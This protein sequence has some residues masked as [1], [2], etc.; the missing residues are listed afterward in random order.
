ML[1]VDAAEVAVEP[2]DGAVSRETAR[3]QGEFEQ[4]DPPAGRGSRGLLDPEMQSALIMYIF[5][6]CFNN[7]ST[8]KRRVW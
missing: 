1:S 6:L 3:D 7:V 2:V 8:H 5:L 4:A